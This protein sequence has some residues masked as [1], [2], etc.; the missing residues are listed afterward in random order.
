MGPTIYADWGD[1]VEITVTNHLKDNGTGIH[2]HGIRQWRS[3]YEDGVP[4]VTE[5]PLAPGQSK[6]YRWQATQYGT[7]WYH[8]HLGVQ[9]GDGVLGAMVVNGP[10]TA[11][12]DVDLGPLP[13]SDWYYQTASTR[14]YIVAH[15]NGRPPTTADNGLINSTMVSKKGTGKYAVT[16]ITKGKKYKLRLIN[17]AVDNHFKVSLDN[18]P[19]QVIAADFI[20]IKPYTANWIFIAIG[21]R[22]DVI[23]NA[24]QN[25][26]NYWF[27]AEVQ[28]KAGPDCGLN[29]N[30]GNIKSIFRYSG[31]PASN[32]TSSATAYTQSC[33]DE[34]V[35]PFWDSFVPS[36]PLTN[37][38]QLNTAINIGVQSGA[39]TVKWGINTTAMNVM[40]DKPILQY[41][42]EGNTSYP[43]AANLISL[44]AQDQWWYWVVQEVAGTPIS[45]NIPHPIHLHGHDFFVLGQGVG[46]FS[47]TGGSTL[48]YDNPIRRDTAML[49]AGGWLAVA[50]KT[51]NPGA[52]LMHCHIAWHVSEGMAVQ[53]LESADQISGIDP[54][55]SSFTDTCAGWNSYYPAHSA[56]LRDADDSG[57]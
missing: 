17:A 53:F 25:V 26:G 50:F 24:N 49:P 41:V 23:I 6:V 33:S 46:Q 40:W 12:Y 43:A 21:Q 47:S 35:V 22:Y 8:S 54:A 29:A 14:S 38:G 27:R 20:P 10:S 5:C 45:I 52:W 30:N 42:Q 44:P 11:N 55:A 2:W 13:V 4:G 3:N 37:G 18:H 39:T 31:A 15:T 1:Y 16:N 9:Y 57:V 34:V 48:N 56:Y 32:P 36:E 7:S 19:F 51:D 28:D